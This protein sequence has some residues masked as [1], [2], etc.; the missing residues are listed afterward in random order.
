MTNTSAITG[1]EDGVTVRGAAGTI[2]NYG[3]IIATVDD[4]IGLFAGGSVTNALGASIS[5]LGTLG[6]GIYIT[7]GAGTITNAGSLSGP[8]HHAV[9]MEGGGTVSNL[10]SGSISALGIGVFLKN[11]TGDGDQRGPDY[12]DRD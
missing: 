5:G 9:L 12:R 4:G 2:A 8:N 11:Q 7:G 10:A 6:A 1:G 3:S